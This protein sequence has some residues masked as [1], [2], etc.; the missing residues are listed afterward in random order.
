[1]KLSRLSPLTL[2]ITYSHNNNNSSYGAT[3]DPREI[4]SN[5]YV[6]QVKDLMPVMVV[7]G[8]AQQRV[9]EVCSNNRY[10]CLQIYIKDSSEVDYLENSVPSSYINGL[11]LRGRVAD[12]DF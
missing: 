1:M 4:P 3:I 7:N 11:L 2:L 8:S 5:Y 6:Q 10:V 9:T 12:N